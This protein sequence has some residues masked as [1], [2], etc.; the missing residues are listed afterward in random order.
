MAQPLKLIFAGTPDFAAIHLQGILDQDDHEV[1]AVYSQPDRP[2]GRGKKLK[3]SAV[4]QVA[5]DHDIPV[6]QPL[7]FKEP[8]DQQTLKD[9]GADLMV[10]VAYGL[11]LPKSFS[12]PLAW[13]ASMFTL[14]YCPAGVAPPQSSGPLK[15]AIKKAA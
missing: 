6:F 2:A 8:T 9:L 12:T 5:L 4:K 11:L 3:P 7:N 13:A 15:Q 10:V 1:I 14:L